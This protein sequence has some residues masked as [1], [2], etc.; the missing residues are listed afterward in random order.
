MPQTLFA[1]VSQTELDAVKA[2]DWSAMR[3]PPSG[4]SLSLWTDRD[5]ALAAGP[6]PNVDQNS[7]H[8]VVEMLARHGGDQELDW[9]PERHRAELRADQVPALNDWLG[10]GGISV[11]GAFSPLSQGGEPAFTM[12]DYDHAGLWDQVYNRFEFRP[13]LGSDELPWSVDVSSVTFSIEWPGDERALDASGLDAMRRVVTAG[14][15]FV[16]LDWQHP[17]H[18]VWPHALG[19]VSELIP[20][21]ILPDGDY[22]FH[23]A[24]DL[25][26]GIFGH[27]WQQ[28]LTVFGGRLIEAFEPPSFLKPVSSTTELRGSSLNATSNQELWLSLPFPG[29]SDDD[30]IGELH[31]DLAM[32]DTFV[33][34]AVLAKKLLEVHVLVG[35]RREVGEFLE[36]AENVATSTPEVNEYLE[37]AHMLARVLDDDLS[38][39]HSA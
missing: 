22:Y 14:D 29:G 16:S 26:F 9:P 37:Y 38:R 17:T 32:L 21:P 39:R 25:A 19:G 15:S 6:Q 28:I 18:I 33:A 2:M 31:S 3:A 34:D 13:S 30:E 8:Y 20:T 12:A 10:W 1:I 36:S 7:A 23:V 27:P 11:A 4:G 5:R 35:L 24:A